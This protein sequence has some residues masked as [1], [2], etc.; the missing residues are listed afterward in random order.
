[1]DVTISQEGG[2][3][4]TWSDYKFAD[5]SDWNN[6]FKPGQGTL[7][8]FENKGG[9]RGP[10]LF[11]TKIPLTPGPLVVVIKPAQAQ[12]FNASG[13]QPYWP[14]R[15]PDQ[16][17]TIAASYVQPGSEG[18]LRLFNL[19]PDTKRAGVALAGKSL[20]TDVAF[21][22]GS[23]WSTVPAKSETFDFTDSATGKTLLSKIET[24]PRAPIGT[25]SFLLGEQKPASADMGIQVVALNDAPEGGKCHP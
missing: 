18:S 12:A 19:S 3:S 4:F 17:E 10:A 25:T 16:V 1:M 20:A 15:D 8:V 21:S 5:F 6:L 13:P 11:T 7:T 24:P 2:I 23:P 22:L 9:D 14:P